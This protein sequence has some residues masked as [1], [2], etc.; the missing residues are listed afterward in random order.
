MLWCSLVSV[1]GMARVIAVVV[2]DDDQ[3][4]FV[5]KSQNLY[6]T[7]GLRCCCDWRLVVRLFCACAC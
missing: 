3:L 5:E 1:A 7:H 6:H 2:D 4:Y